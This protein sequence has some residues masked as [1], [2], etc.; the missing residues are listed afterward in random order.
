MMKAM[1]DEEVEQLAGP[2]HAHSERRQAFRWGSEVGHVIFTG[3]KAA[4]AK[5]RVRSTDGKE[6]PLRHYNAF[7]EGPWMQDGVSRRILCRVF[8]SDCK[9]V[10]DDICDGCGIDKSSVSRQWKAACARHC[11]AG[12]REAF[13]EGRTLSSEAAAAEGNQGTC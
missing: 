10:I 3:R 6:I 8:T 9:G 13:P 12:S 11:S 4:I 7:G 5:P 2:R 1:I